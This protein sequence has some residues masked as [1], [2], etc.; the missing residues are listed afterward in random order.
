MISRDGAGR[1]D[2]NT[3]I[4]S[5]GPFLAC[6]AEPRHHLREVCE[7][8]GF[9][10]MG[11]EAGVGGQDAVV[12]L[13]VAG[14]GDERDVLAAGR[15]LQPPRQFV[16][17]MTGRPISRRATSGRPPSQIVADG[18]EGDAGRVSDGQGRGEHSAESRLS[19]T[20]RCAGF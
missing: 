17:T 6:P 11:F 14:D 7:V 5:A 15:A 1:P 4:E 8:D 2:R 20:I 12:V 13:A 9:D 19:S 3:L 10:E 16:A 18:V